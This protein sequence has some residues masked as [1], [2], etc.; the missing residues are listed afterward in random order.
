MTSATFAITLYGLAMLGLGWY[1]RGL[2]DKFQTVDDLRDLPGLN[3]S[4]E[5]S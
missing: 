4:E 5:K 3:R 2:W 1:L